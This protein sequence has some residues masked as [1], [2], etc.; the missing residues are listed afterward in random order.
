[1]SKLRSIH[2]SCE[3]TD[4]DTQLESQWHEGFE[5]ML[6]DV[7]AVRDQVLKKF[8]LLGDFR[9]AFQ[10]V[11]GLCYLSLPKCLKVDLF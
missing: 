4:R 8:I 10:V 1:M 6:L 5:N 3:P 2:L 11:A 7:I 9:V